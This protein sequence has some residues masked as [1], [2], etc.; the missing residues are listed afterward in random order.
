MI[1]IGMTVR[2]IVSMASSTDSPDLYERIIKALE[3]ATN[4]AK[5]LVACDNIKKTGQYWEHKIPAIKA[6][7]RATGW[8]LKESKEWV[9]SCQHDS[10]TN[11]TPPLSQE[12]AEKL[13]TEL[14]ACGCECWVLNA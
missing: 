10:K 8:G 5:K 9:E 14:T 1:N 3:E 2:E 13:R 12:V 11:F 4:T 7:R 6:V